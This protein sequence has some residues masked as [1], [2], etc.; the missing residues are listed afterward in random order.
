M[1]LAWC[2]VVV[3]FAFYICFR[4]NVGRLVVIGLWCFGVGGLEGGDGWVCPNRFCLLGC[5]FG[6]PCGTVCLLAFCV[7]FIY[8]RLAVFVSLLFVT[9]RLIF[10]LDKPLFLFIVSF[11]FWWAY[12]VIG[13]CRYCVLLISC[14]SFTSIFVFSLLF[15]FLLFDLSASCDIGRSAMATAGG[16]PRLLVPARMGREAMLFVLIRSPCGPRSCRSGHM[17]WWIGAS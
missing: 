15:L 17:G 8:T 3:V 12:S 6:L 10:S 7:L 4:R 5:R 14:P 9:V 16:L 13:D 1:F 11:L 2:D